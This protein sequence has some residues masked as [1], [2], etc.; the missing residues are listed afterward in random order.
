MSRGESQTGRDVLSDPPS[1]F[2]TQKQPYL[3]LMCNYHVCLKGLE[4]SA[5]ILTRHAD[6]KI[7]HP[8]MMQLATNIPALAGHCTKRVY[9][10]STV[11]SLLDD[12]KKGK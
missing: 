8:C 1:S 10:T 3:M 4:Q 2:S 11:T 9:N 12:P 6:K 5:K 7:A